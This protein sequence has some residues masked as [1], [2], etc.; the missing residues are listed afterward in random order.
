MRAAAA[1]GRLLML[2][3]HLNSRPIAMKCNVQAGVGSF[4]LKIAYDEAYASYSPGVHLELEN[5]RRFH[6]HPQLQW[7]DS[8][9]TSR[10][11][12]INR[13]WTARRSLK[14]VVIATGKGG[15]NFIVA[16]L[17]L[18]RWGKRKLKIAPSSE[19]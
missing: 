14:R 7:M 5:V 4:S 2:A 17:P 16:A 11:F 6:E 1:R 18:L 13:L 15:G 9:A 3:L 8:C 10:H 19:E 12:M